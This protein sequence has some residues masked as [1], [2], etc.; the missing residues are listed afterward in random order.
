ML[1]EKE[2]FPPR[3]LNPVKIFFRND[4]GRHDM[5]KNKARNVSRKCVGEGREDLIFKV[6]WSMRTFLGG[7]SYSETGKR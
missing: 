4:G 3:I 1:K 5:E 2:N 7:E 6:E